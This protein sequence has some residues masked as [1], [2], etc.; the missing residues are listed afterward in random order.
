MGKGK[1]EREA[2]RVGWKAPEERAV[3]ATTNELHV[4]DEEPVFWMRNL[5]FG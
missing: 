3:G 1:R 4:L 5:C 2:P